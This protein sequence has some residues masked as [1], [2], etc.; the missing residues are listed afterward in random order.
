[1]NNT[2]IHFG[3][4]ALRLLVLLCATFSAPAL[5]PDRIAFQS[6]RATNGT[7]RHPIVIAA[8]ICAMNRD[9]TGVVQ[10]TNGT[11]DAASPK[12]SPDRAF[13]SFVRDGMLQVME[14]VGEANGG[15]TFAVAPAA[16]V[17]SDW[18]PNGAQI[19]FVAAVDGGAPGFGLWIVD[20]NAAA[21]TVGTPVLVRGPHCLF[22]AWSPDGSKIAYTDGSTGNSTQVIKVLDLS[23]GSEVTFP[24]IPSLAPSWSPNGSSIA[25]SALNKVTTTSR[26][27]KTT[28]NWYQE[29][30]VGNV[31]GSGAI[32]VTNFRAGVT[33]GPTWSADGGG[34][35]FRASPT[36]TSSIYNLNLTSGSLELLLT[37]GDAPDWGF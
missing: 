36:G 10:L 21:G 7:P 1:M 6:V 16:V 18:S 15:R 22:P 23:S 20:V 19:C 28:T 4:A 35:A 30:F 5:P 8:Q 13:I 24:T 2:T 34:L 14:S 37:G 11:S 32:Q 33:A 12:W 25:F 17:G 26:N 31:D 3:K 27:G 29:I 9:G